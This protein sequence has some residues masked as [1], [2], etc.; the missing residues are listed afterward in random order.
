MTAKPETADERR[1]REQRDRAA[2]VRDLLAFHFHNRLAMDPDGAPRAA[3]TA[4][5]TKVIF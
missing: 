3:P 4:Y 2:M 5:R 1:Q